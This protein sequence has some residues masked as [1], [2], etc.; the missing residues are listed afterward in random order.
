LVDVNGTLYVLGQKSR[1]LYTFNSTTGKDR[2]KI[3]EF[4]DDPEQI[5]FA[6]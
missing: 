4:S 1:A 6:C 5:I 3:A 2:H